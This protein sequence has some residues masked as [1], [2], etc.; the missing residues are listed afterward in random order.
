MGNAVPTRVR[1]PLI[2]SLTAGAISQ[3]GNNF[4]NVAIPWYVLATTGSAARMGL[5]G[6]VGLVPTVLGSVFGGAIVDRMG[7]KRI[8][9][10]ADIVSGLAVAGIPLLGAT[11]GI[12]FWE[13]LALVF[14]GALF[15]SPGGTARSAM[16]PDLV[17]VA[18]ATLERANGLSGMV[19]SVVQIGV[20]PLAGVAIGL[21]GAGRVLWIDAASFAISATVYQAFV[22]SIHKPV[23]TSE[24]YREQVFGGF[25]FIRA[26]SLLMT[27]FVFSAFVNLLTN[28]FFGVVITVLAHDNYGSARALGWML[29][30]P[31]VGALASLALYSRRGAKWS[32]RLTV[33]LGFA[34]FS[35]PLTIAAY[36][37]TL[38]IAVIALAVS[39]FGAGPINAVLFTLLQERTPAAMRGRVFGSVIA[40]VLVAAPLGVLSTGTLVGI[41]GAR[42]I[43]VG[44]GLLVTVGAGLLAVVP[45]L[46]D[47]DR[48][49]EPALNE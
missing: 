47:M 14:V 32:R 1:L 19:Q 11:V 33:V 48:R 12:Q 3:A 6:F 10:F 13:L 49:V 7:H 16:L 31:G 36:T 18:G 21:M 43:G 45:T 30:A 22:P 9:V 42:P 39:G 4:T 25:R 38:W 5:V 24:S 34:V 29:G 2:A 28:S 44:I 41:A 26:S 35:V 46:R 20:P 27:L 17:E 15:D 37:Q 23:E 8:S 40:L